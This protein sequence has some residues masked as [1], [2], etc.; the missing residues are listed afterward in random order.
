MPPHA[1][2]ADV[3]TGTAI[4]AID[5]ASKSPSTYQFD[6]FDISDA[7]YPSQENLPKNVRL[8]VAD[9][10]QPF[11]EHFRGQF[12]AIHLRLLVCALEKD[13]WESV[14]KN[15]LDLLKPGGAIQ[16]EEINAA[17]VESLRGGPKPTSVATMAKIRKM[18]VDGSGSRLEYGWNILQDV[19]LKF[20]MK[21]VDVDILSSDRIPEARRIV[22]TCIL[23]VS[24]GFVRL[25]LK[26]GKLDSVTSE[27]LDELEK[28]AL[29][30]INAGG[31]FREV[32]YVSYGFKP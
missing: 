25:M 7:Q 10:K 4:W 5:L 19:F 15:I 22:T 21:D 8:H 9:A 28:K 14:T 27:E 26:T 32:M 30:E 31:Y 23:R 12:D 18:L 20:G 11:P 17:K 16:W 1:R 29:L 24:M 3:G 2:I 6:G 13:E